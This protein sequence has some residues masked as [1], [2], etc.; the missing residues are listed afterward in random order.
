MLSG[1]TCIDSTIGFPLRHF[2]PEIPGSMLGKVNF[3]ALFPSFFFFL[4]LD[5]SIP[6]SVGEITELSS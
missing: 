2:D 1:H 4:V 3:Q 5:H 6:K